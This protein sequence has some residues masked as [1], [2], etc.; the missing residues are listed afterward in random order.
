M[1]IVNNTLTTIW[2]DQRKGKDQVLNSVDLPGSEEIRKFVHDLLADGET[3]MA[4]IH[5]SGRGL[6]IHICG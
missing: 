5:I 4:F 2:G 3:E 6:L 1:G